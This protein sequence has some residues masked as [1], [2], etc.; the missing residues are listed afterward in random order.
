MSQTKVRFADD[1]R[2]TD[3]TDDSYYARRAAEHRLRLEATGDE[4]AR[5]AHR[6]LAAAYERHAI[7]AILDRSLG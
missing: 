6:R 2:H 3:E 4:R 7:R 1:M 5:I